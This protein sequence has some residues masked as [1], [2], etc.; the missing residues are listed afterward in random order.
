[1]ANLLEY[2]LKKMLIFA[3]KILEVANMNHNILGRIFVQIAEF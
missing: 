2:K 3:Q 1:M